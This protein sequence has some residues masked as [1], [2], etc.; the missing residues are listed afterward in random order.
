MKIAISGIGLIS[1]L[2][3]NLAENLLQLQKM[4]HGI[5]KYYCNHRKTT[6][7]A[8]QVQ[9]SNAELKLELGFDENKNISR[10]SLLGIVAAKECWTNIP[11]DSPL[12]A[13]LICG[14][15][16]GGID[17]SE[18]KYENYLNTSE[19]NPADYSTHDSGV[20]TTTIANSIAKFQY[21]NTISTACSSGSNALLLGAR[22]IASGQLDRVL[23]GGSDAITNFTCAGFSS[24][25][26]YD[27]NLCTPF[28]AERQGLNLGEGAAFLLL[29]ND[30]ALA[31]RKATALAY[32]YGGANTT[33]AHHQTA[34]SPDGKGA[35]LAMQEALEMAQCNAT[36][37]D[38]IN[39]H[40]TATPNNDASES[41]ALKT[42]FGEK[43]P[44]FSSTK[45]YTGHTL[46]ASGAIEAVFSVLS[47]LNQ[48]L[49]PTLR[50]KNPIPETGL[51]PVKTFQQASVN[52]VL[53]NSFGFGGNCT[54]III[55]K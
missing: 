23:V 1:A 49:Y 36:D 47:L 45:S 44:H 39:A 51:S 16:V 5:S 26:I 18:L 25:M 30:K 8:A 54:S 13:G 52:K 38:Y 28:D 7:Y 32:Y 53:S 24:L 10:T 2:G 41:V 40:G 11:K 50:F 20:C 29:E 35:V 21:I 34:S 22:L 48:E 12:K 27:Q 46:A 3:N 4:Q 43:P 37:I 14:T 42:I 17:I 19:L 31:E 55:G 9:T 15:S 33:D 6:F